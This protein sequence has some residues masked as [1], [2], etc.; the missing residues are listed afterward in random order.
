VAAAARR[1]GLEVVGWTGSAKD[2]V[3]TDPGRAL[4]RLLRATR[5]GSILVLHDGA[6]QGDREPVALR[7][8]P[9]LLDELERRGLRSVTLD[10]LLAYRLIS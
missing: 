5:P 10:E 2:G 3:P 6:E 4:Q 9:R 8:L 7:I 1:V